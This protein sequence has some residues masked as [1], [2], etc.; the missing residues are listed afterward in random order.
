MSYRIPSCLP[1]VNRGTSTRARVS[2]EVGPPSRTAA[3]EALTA[4]S[5]RPRQNPG[6]G[7]DG[8]GYAQT[9]KIPPSARNRA[10]LLAESGQ[11]IGDG[12]HCASAERLW[13]EEYA[14]NRH[15]APLQVQSVIDTIDRGALDDI[16]S[17]RLHPCSPSPGY[18][19]PLIGEDTGCDP[20]AHDAPPIQ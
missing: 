2:P 15:V 5:R 17:V 8:C 13:S 19:L 16:S 10:Q 6:V 11:Q 7:S 18:P 20:V 12:R 4:T 1:G 3:P 14:Q 9:R